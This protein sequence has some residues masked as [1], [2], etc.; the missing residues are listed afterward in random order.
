MN[1][2]FPLITAAIIAGTLL[3]VAVL[4]GVTI[5]PNQ[6]TYEL[7]AMPANTAVP[8]P[9]PT[10]AQDCRQKG[11]NLVRAGLL[12]DFMC[13]TRDKYT[14]VATCTG[15]PAPHI[16]LT[17]NPEDPKLWD[18]PAARAIQPDAKDDTRWDTV[19]W[20]YV[21]APG[22]PSGYPNCWT[23]GDADPMEWCVNGTDPN[24]PFMQ[25]KEEPGACPEIPN[26]VE[27]V[28]VPPDFLAQWSTPESC[29]QRHESCVIYPKGS[30]PENCGPPATKCSMAENYY[31]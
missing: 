4:A 17:R 5:N 9:W 20:L 26:T 15:E 24:A 18:E 2:G 28:A 23:R 31:Q 11:E 6:S 16:A 7:R 25:R 22:W 30:P 8:G 19:Q 29:A 12:A 14:V 1:R 27:A 10:S 21:H 13:V 3:A